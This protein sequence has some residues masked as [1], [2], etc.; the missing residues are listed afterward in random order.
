MRL[1]LLVALSFVFLGP[2]F[3]RGD[4]W[5]WTFAALSI[6]AFV[7][8]YALT[9]MA[10]DQHR[11]RRALALTIGMAAYGFA[12]IP[13]TLGANT[14]VVY[15]AAFVPFLVRPAKAMGYFL[16]L[17]AGLLLVS[18]ALPPI[19]RGWLVGPTA[20]LVIMVGG[21]NVFYAEH[22]RRN[23]RLWRVQEEVEEMAT[24][25]ERE[26]ISRDLHDLLGHTLS[27]IALKSELASRLADSDPGRAAAEIRDVERVSRDALSEVRTAVEGY[28]GRGLSGE[29]RGAARALESS[30]VQMSATIADIR[31]SVRHE[32][33]LALAM[34]EA[35]TNV[36]RHARA[37]TCWITLRGE[38]ARLVFSIR[39]NGVGGTPREGHGLTGMR[40]RVAAAG[41]TVTVDGSSGTTITIALPTASDAID[42][43]TPA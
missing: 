31:M 28:R 4:R 37:S 36:V 2:M 14:Y 16:L 32:T 6:V 38:Q 40:E 21:V 1:F 10:V 9:W 30:G 39:D 33:I 27:V 20:F 5:D 34:R 8:V 18:M 12:L 29:L 13:F 25:A 43:Q 11:E 15:S 26:R 17:I 42:S 7:P 22:Q 23:A 19:A 35:V 24:L 3:G 41:G